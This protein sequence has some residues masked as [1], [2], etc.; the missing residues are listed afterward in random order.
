M[1]HDSPLKG[2]TVKGHLVDGLIRGLQGQL[3]GL[4]LVSV[5][6]WLRDGVILGIGNMDIIIRSIDI[7]ISSMDTIIRRMA[8]I[9]R[10]MDIIIRSMD[11]IIRSL[12]IIILN[13]ILSVISSVT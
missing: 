1:N 2:Q 13:C 9:S 7:I 12:A 6:S 3:P 5:L 8:I 10:S 11:I 4:V